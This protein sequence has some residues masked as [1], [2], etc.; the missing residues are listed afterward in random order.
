MKQESYRKLPAVSDTN[1][2]ILEMIMILRSLTV[3]LTLREK[4]EGD[5]VARGG[6]SVGWVTERGNVQSGDDSSGEEQLPSVI[7]QCP[8]TSSQTLCKY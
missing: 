2:E 8:I 1:R 7:S 3:Q 6:M 4:K 5:G